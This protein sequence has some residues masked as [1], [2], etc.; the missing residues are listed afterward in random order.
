[1]KPVRFRSCAAL[2]LVLMLTT[3]QTGYL[4]ASVNGDTVSSGR[5]RLVAVST[6]GALGG[7]G[8]LGGL[9]FLWYA[10]YP[11]S[12][13]HWFNDNGQWLMMDKMGH[14][15]SAY[16]ISR[17]SSA[18]IQW[19]GQSRLKSG[20]IG[21]GVGFAY[22]GV[23]EL[24]DGF[25][26]G[27][28]ASPGDLLANSLGTGLFLGQ[29]YLWKSQ[30]ISLKW[31][32]QRSR[33]V[34]S[35]PDLLGQNLVQ[36]MLKDYNGQTYWLSFNLSDFLASDS[37]LLP[38]WLCLSFGYG[39]SGMLGGDDNPPAFSHI[40][41]TRQYY[42]SLDADLSRIPVSNP[43]LKAVFSALSFIKLPAPALSLESGKL[44][45]HPI[46]F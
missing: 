19:T 35:R 14:A 41:R 45:F 20:L 13:F 21:A 6:V 37:G 22:L 23:V 39:A 44:A 29:E 28:G 17:L 36:A 11:S 42:L 9:Y 30:R 5:S 3:V 27:W 26:Q 43:R 18:A 38:E 1:M 12:Q 34:L 4:E 8:S 32:F 24:M 7:L 25:S 46:W 10:D 40:E 15:A 16:Q 31:S 2:G 33:Y